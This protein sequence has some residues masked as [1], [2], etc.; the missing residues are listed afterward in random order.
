MTAGDILATS[1][2]STGCVPHSTALSFE[3]NKVPKQHVYVV[4]MTTDASRL[5][6]TAFAADFCLATDLHTI[7]CAASVSTGCSVCSYLHTRPIS[8]ETK[9]IQFEQVCFP[10]GAPRV[11]SHVLCACSLH[12]LGR[13]KRFSYRVTRGRLFALT[14]NVSLRRRQETIARHPM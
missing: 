4:S 7:S 13:M 2:L 3:Q 11:T 14:S 1:S 6:T 8:C 10:Q 9:D 5:A 12:V